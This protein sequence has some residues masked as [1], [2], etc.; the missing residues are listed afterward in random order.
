MNNRCANSK[1]RVITKIGGCITIL[2]VLVLG[3]CS[4]TDLTSDAVDTVTP[5]I[6]LNRFVDVRLASIQQEAARGEGE[7]LDALAQLMGK[8]DR[9]AFSSWMHDNYNALFSDLEKPSQLISRIEAHGNDL[10]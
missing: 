7:N 10:I 3:G 5:D 8:T 9:R 6:T 1:M 4:I 2:A